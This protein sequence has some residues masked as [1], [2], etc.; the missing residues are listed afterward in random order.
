MVV[1]IV[2]VW[3]YGGCALSGS[4]CTDRGTG[5]VYRSTRAVLTPRLVQI[6]RL[7]MS[8]ETDTNTEA[9]TDTVCAD[10]EER[11]MRVAELA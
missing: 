6:Q 9:R 11:S 8:T 1:R 7:V 5:I 2:C 10:M 3:W 4:G